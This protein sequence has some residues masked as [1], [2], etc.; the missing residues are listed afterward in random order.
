[1]APVACVSCGT[2]LRDGARFCDGCGS[3]TT[4]ETGRAEYKQVT[5]LFADVV[6]SMDIAATVGAE[7]LREIMADL[8]DRATSVVERY[9]GTVDKFTGDGIMALFGAPKAL[10]DHAAR[11]CRAALDLQ[12]EAV[13]LSDGLV[14]LD[15]I[16]LSLRIGL[17]SGQVIAGEVGAAKLGYTAIGEQVGMA[18]RM[19]SAA[20]SGGVM[21]SESTARLVADDAVLSE[22]KSLSIKGFTEPVLGRELLGLEVGTQ[23][24]RRRAAKL[25]G[26]EWELTA[27]TAMLDQSADGQGRIVGIAGAPGIGK[28]RLAA[29]LA[30]LA[31]ARGLEVQWAVCESHTSDV[32]FHVVADL[33]RASSEIR[34][35]DHAAAREL[36]RERN[37]D[38]DPDDLLL[39][40]DLMGIAD[41]TVPLP[42]IDPDARRRRVTALVW[43]ALL[44]REIPGVFII[45][46]VH[47]VD[48]VSESM[49]ADFGA[50]IPQSRALAVFTYRPEY[51]GLLAR[52]PGAQT[53][54]LAPLGTSSSTSLITELL[55]NDPSVETVSSA[56]SARAAGNPLFTE[57]M[58]RDL[59]EQGV[60]IGKRGAYRCADEVPEFSVP[61]TLQ[62]AIAARIDR[63]DA[64]S[65]RCL[66]AAAAIGMR[67]N[68]ALIERLGV[69]AA[70][71]QLI[72]AEL[73][74]P[75]LF[76]RED[77]FAF[78]HPM[79]RTVAY[80][81]QLRS[82][83]AEIHRNLA[84]VL[85]RSDPGAADE[86]AALIAE[87]YDAA[88][89]WA[90]AYDWH[91]RAA[92]WSASR[93]IRAA[94]T[95]WR[96]AR[97]AA[98]RLPGQDSDTLAKRVAARTSL[99]A[100][101]WRSDDAIAD[102]GFDELRELCDVSGDKVSL[103][104]G[105][106]GAVTATLFDRRYFDAARMSIDNVA[107]LEAIGDPAL[108]AGTSMAAVNALWQA[109]E[110]TSA[111]R[112][113]ER[114]IEFAGGDPTMGAWVMGS[115]LAVCH[116]LRGGCLYTLGLAGVREEFDLAADIA[117][118]RDTTSYLAVL[119]WRS[120][121]IHNG[122]LTADR[123]DLDQAR[124][125]LRIAELSG[126]DF[127]LNSART[128]VA[129]VLTH[130]DTGQ[131]PGSV[132][133]EVMQ[134][135]EDVRTQR[136][137]NPIWMPRFDQIAATL[138][139]RRGDYDA[140]IELI[141]SIIGDDLAAGIT[142][143]A[144]QGTTVLVECLLRRGAP[145]DLE[146]AEAAIER[147]AAEPVEPGFIPD[148]LPLLRIRALLAE[149][150]G[151]HASYVD[152]RD[153]Y[154]E[155][156]RRVDFKPH[157]AMAEAMP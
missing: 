51:Q 45:E 106:S 24:T 12:A 2:V 110:A 137:A 88:G 123:A 111:L 151:D 32:P 44:S 133:A 47:W 35:L 56:I 142:V 23:Q 100:S 146:E 136:Y 109:G 139:M 74:E 69:D 17:N 91:M 5:V 54:S 26:R 77:R 150:R 66:G 153:R 19:E 104:I 60:L 127:G 135:R 144:G 81:S 138:T 80:E 18:Q 21:L 33:L 79:I 46:D 10:E 61:V 95:N 84:S 148:E 117:R 27:L 82:D 119:L 87:H 99:C 65:K 83:R 58:V 34:G 140:A 132:E 14:A 43:Q 15:G 96:R 90:A 126:D 154:R 92:S 72:A 6:H 93:D 64:A 73:I 78:R 128:F 1:M 105:M 67:F 70:L 42:D 115:P 4:V 112:L 30:A 130:G 141:G 9:G 41:P 122:A 145:G 124:Q 57:E 52:V 155:M 156:A 38:A 147:L 102:T 121:A 125:A 29:E 55:G 53:I 8:V 85:E 48:Q 89:E 118:G 113:I 149:A 68:P 157:I 143:A 97:D 59:V 63:L 116:A 11:A 94:Q 107:L 13:R 129:A 49:L 103:A 101:A 39:F 25:V 20:P 28:S 98:D 62:A 22:P 76:S 75:V 50:V 7:R 86:N 37:P 3:P 31:Q 108:F 16:R 120:F 134:I 114:A 71:D 131:S 40:G 152:Y 36:V